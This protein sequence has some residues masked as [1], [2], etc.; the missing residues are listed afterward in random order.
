MCADWTPLLT[1]CI[2]EAGVGVKVGL[3]TGSAL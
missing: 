3:G 2:N 1:K